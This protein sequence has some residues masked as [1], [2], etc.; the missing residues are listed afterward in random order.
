M[1]E[2]SPA[3]AASENTS[4]SLP[5]HEGAGR[6]TQLLLPPPAHRAPGTARSATGRLVLAWAVVSVPLGY[7]ITQTLIKAAQLFTG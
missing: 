7:G 5:G 4:A 3:H 6:R 2:R 1:S